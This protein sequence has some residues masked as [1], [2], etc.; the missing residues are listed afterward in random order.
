M[1]D[2]LATIITV[3]SLAL[4]VKF[5]P[6]RGR[7]IVPVYGEPPRRVNGVSLA[8]DLKALGRHREG[9]TE[10]W[11]VEGRGIPLL[12]GTALVDAY[13]TVTC[14]TWQAAVLHWYA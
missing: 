13:Q 1:V 2:V 3:A 7:W 5:R 6:R 11:V 9:P 14:S 8:V 4:V 12:F 10:W